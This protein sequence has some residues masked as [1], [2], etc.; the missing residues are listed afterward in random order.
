MSRKI[1]A[2]LE[3]QLLVTRQDAA[4]MLGG[5]SIMTI[6]RLDADKNLRPIRLNSSSP[7]ARVFYNTEDLIALAR[8]RRADITS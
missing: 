1:Q 4:R 3:Q 6:I 2:V 8:A 5:V 7:N